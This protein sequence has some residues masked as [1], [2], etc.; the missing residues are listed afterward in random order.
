[1]RSERGAATVL[2]IS[3]SAVLV[4]VGA[5]CALVGGVVIDHR[6]AQNAADLAALAGARALADGQ[7]AC[8]AAAAVARRNDA[9]LTEC[10]I[11]GDDVRVR[12]GVEPAWLQG[13][14]IQAEARAG[15]TWPRAEGSVVSAGRGRRGP[16]RGAARRR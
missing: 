11:A 14:T 2:V 15:P 10:T 6:R 8:A 9:A 3:F 7:D 13:R 5:A 16:S 4:V 12:V 1:M